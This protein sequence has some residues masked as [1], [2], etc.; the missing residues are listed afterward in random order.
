MTYDHDGVIHDH[1]VKSLRSSLGSHGAERYKR[2][3]IMEIMA[4]DIRKAGG[5]LN[6][7]V[8]DNSCEVEFV[9][10]NG[11][12]IVLKEPDETRM[13]FPSENLLAR[14]ALVAG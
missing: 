14:I 3:T 11:N 2:Y 1:M 10:A 6:W 7:S 9:D 8:T 5:E 13:D 4:T 12:K